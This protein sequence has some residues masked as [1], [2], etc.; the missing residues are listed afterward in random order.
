M[1]IPF[2]RIP[3]FANFSLCLVLHLLAHAKPNSLQPIHV[4]CLLCHHSPII[5][6][7]DK[8]KNVSVPMNVWSIHRFKYKWNT[9]PNRQEVAVESHLIDIGF[10]VH[11]IESWRQIS[12]I[13]T[14]NSILFIILHKCRTTISELHH[15]HWWGAVGLGDLKG[16]T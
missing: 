7:N 10:L 15:F 12:V 2:Q 13:W 9:I 4:V 1:P 11:L 14:R 6:A 16:K 5:S 8:I 3:K